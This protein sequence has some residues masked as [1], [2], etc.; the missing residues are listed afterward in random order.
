MER[1]LNYKDVDKDVETKE[2]NLDDIVRNVNEKLRYEREVENKR[3]DDLRI[4][5]SKVFDTMFV[6]NSDFE[7]LFDSYQ[8]RKNGD[9]YFLLNG[10]EIVGY[11]QSSLHNDVIKIFDAN[12][13]VSNRY[14]NVFLKAFSKSEGMFRGLFWIDRES[15]KM[16]YTDFLDG[17]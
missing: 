5:I 2:K 4:K 8:F 1:S 15:G 7:F 10:K 12:I 11:M 14:C 3:V 13:S 16:N 17:L 6:S 9:E